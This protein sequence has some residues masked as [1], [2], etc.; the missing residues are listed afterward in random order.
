MSGGLSARGYGVAWFRHRVN[1]HQEVS[2]RR[3][4]WWIRI[5]IRNTQAKEGRELPKL[6]VNEWMTLDEVVLALRKEAAPR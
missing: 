3:C 5:W 1:L 4:R 6:I 2:G